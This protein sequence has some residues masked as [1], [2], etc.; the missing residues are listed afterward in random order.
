MDNRKLVVLRGEMHCSSCCAS[1]FLFSHSREWAVVS[2]LLL[3]GLSAGR[4]WIVACEVVHFLCSQVQFS[5]ALTFIDHFSL[6]ILSPQ[7]KKYFSLVLLDHV[8]FEFTQELHGHFPSYGY[9]GG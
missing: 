3:E 7:Q 8:Y 2:F 1:K 5:P 6:S 4:C 9:C